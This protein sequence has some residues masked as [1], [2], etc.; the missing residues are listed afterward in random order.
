M[1]LTTQTISEMNDEDL[2]FEFEAEVFGDTRRIS[3]DPPSMCE[4]LRNE[5]WRRMQKN[6]ES[7]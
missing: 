1:E 7:S 4:E 6:E 3:T 2:V 5:I